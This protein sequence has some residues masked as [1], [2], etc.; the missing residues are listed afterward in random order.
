MSKLSVIY[1][2]WLCRTAKGY[3]AWLRKSGV[4]IGTNFRLYNHKTISIDTSSPGLLKIGNNVAITANV[5]ILTHDFCSWVF[6]NL[7]NDYIPGRK[8]VVIGN[9]VYIGQRAMILKGVTIGDNVIIAAGSVVTK[10]VPSNSVV[11]GVPAKILSSLDVYY[12]KRKQNMLSDV[13]EYAQ[14]MFDYRGEYNIYDFKEEFP[15]F[16]KN[17][18]QY[19]TDFV[20]QI[21][22]VQLHG[23]SDAFFAQNVPLFENFDDMINHWKK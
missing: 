4:E 15:L 12:Q 6:R 20:Q 23:I 14:N 19:P 9:N 7:Y 16:M 5:T 3:E 21:K 2:K 10:D 11:A 1:K 18:N 13:R 8:K 17:P 22:N